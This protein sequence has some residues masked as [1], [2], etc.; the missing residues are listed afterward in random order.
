MQGYALQGDYNEERNTE[1]SLLIPKKVLANIIS[2]ALE[3]DPEE[4]C[5]VLIGSESVVDEARRLRNAHTQPIRRFEMPPMDLMRVESE[6]EAKGRKI[7]AIYHSHTHT[8]AY[9]SQTD[10]RNAVES[11]WTDP[12]YV[13]ISLVEKTRPIVRAYR[14]SEDATV[15][16][17]PITTDG[18][19]YVEVTR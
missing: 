13:L 16:E 18:Q 17:I 4:C 9:P 8:Q 19:A 6:A 11:W 12:Y 2:H 5:G 15:A 3:T 10:V 14:I 1:M 7:V